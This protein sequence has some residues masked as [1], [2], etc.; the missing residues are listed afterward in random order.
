MTRKR[1]KDGLEGSSG[2]LTAML[3]IVGFDLE[4]VESQF[5]CLSRMLRM[6]MCVGRRMGVGGSDWRLNKVST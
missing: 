6:I 5:L 4:A 3:R 1:L 2:V